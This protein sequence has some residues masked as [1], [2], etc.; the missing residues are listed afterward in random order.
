M[1]ILMVNKFLY[2]NGGSETYILEVGKC[3]S[4]M[5]HEVQYFG[6]EHE[7][8]IVGNSAEIYTKDMDFHGVGIKEK[9]SKL[10]Y[11]FKIIYSKEAA[12]KI[13][14][15]LYDFEPDVVH[16]N[17]INFQL[18]PSIIEAIADFDIKNH[19]DTKIVATAHDYQWICPNHM[20]KR[21]LDGELC[22]ECQNAKFVNCIKHKCIHGSRIRSVIG[23][24]EAIF[25]RIRKTYGILDAVICPSEFIKT[26]LETNPELIG[27]CIVM[28][29][30]LVDEHDSLEMDG[31]IL[32]LGGKLPDRY[33]LYFGRY[34]EEK[35]VMTLIEV[36]KRLSNIDFVFAGNGPLKKDVTSVSNITDIGFLNSYEMHEVIKKAEFVVF[37]SEWYENCPFTVMEAQQFGAPVLASNIGGTPEL[38]EKGASGELFT[39]GQIDEISA[40]ITELWNNKDIIEKYRS[41]CKKVSFDSVMTYCNKL[42]DL[43]CS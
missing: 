6:M 21:P 34:T 7:G 29:N 25:Y 2:P 43:Y 1:K 39:A 20:L 24:I 16:L 11:P 35:G 36:C 14:K 8:R 22:F 18:T 19:K 12:R 9:L 26:K 41:G 28:H 17:N 30:F 42:I 38:I 15:V 10:T 37:P 4:T 13:T 5:G 31:E 33:V 40:L 27:K 32:K 23:C 3:L